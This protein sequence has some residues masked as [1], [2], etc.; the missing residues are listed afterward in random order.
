M[1]REI[2]SHF[3]SHFAATRAKY[4]RVLFINEQRS[5]DF[6]LLSNRGG[7]VFLGYGT[8]NVSYWKIWNKKCDAI[9]SMAHIGWARLV[10]SI[11]LRIVRP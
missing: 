8:M 1:H 4:C 3:G 5:F 9:P 7:Q 11:R 10:I 6:H 2:E